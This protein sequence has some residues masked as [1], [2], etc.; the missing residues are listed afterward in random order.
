MTTAQN[1]SLGSQQTVGIK[2]PGINFLQRLF[3][4]AQK[5][6]LARVAN[7]LCDQRIVRCACQKKGEERKAIPCQKKADKTKT[8][9]RDVKKKRQD[10]RSVYGCRVIDE[11]E[12]VYG[13]CRPGSG[14]FYVISL[15]LSSMNGTKNSRSM[16]RSRSWLESLLLTAGPESGPESPISASLVSS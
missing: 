15:S 13:R 9:T 7:I 1:P 2:H 3:C 11:E 4:R 6:R 5:R 14:L 16:Y 8:W 10:I 12:E